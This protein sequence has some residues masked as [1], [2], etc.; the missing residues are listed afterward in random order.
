MSLKNPVITSD[1]S[2][3]YANMSFFDLIRLLHSRMSL[4]NGKKP[5]L[6]HQISHTSMSNGSI[7]RSSS[8]M[9]PAFNALA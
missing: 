6:L 2:Y 5:Q 7:E 8:A 3:I 4:K 9:L 1:F